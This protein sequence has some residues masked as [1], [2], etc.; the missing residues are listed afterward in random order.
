MPHYGF[1]SAAAATDITVPMTARYAQ[2]TGDL[3]VGSAFDLAPKPLFPRARVPA[4]FPAVRQP[5]DSV[6]PA[7]TTTPV[8]NT[9]DYTK[10]SACATAA[11]GYAVL[12]KA[13]SAGAGVRLLVYS[14]NNVLLASVQYGT[15]STGL[16]NNTDGNY[17]L[18]ELT[19]G[20]FLI[21]MRDGSSTCWLRVVY[22]LGG[23]VDTNQMS[24]NA[25]G[26]SIASASDGGFY[27][28][29]NSANPSL[30]K[31]SAAGTQLW[32]V[33][34]IGSGTELGVGNANNSCVFELANGNVV[35]AWANRYAIYSP[36]GAVVLA[37]AN[38]PGLAGSVSDAVTGVALAGGGFVL[39]SLLPNNGNSKWHTLLSD[40]G[41][42]VRQ[43]SVNIAPGWLR[44]HPAGGYLSESGQTGQYHGYDNTGRPSAAAPGSGL[45]LPL[46]DGRIASIRLVAGSNQIITEIFAGSGF[47]YG[48]ASDTA[49]AGA[50]ATVQVS[51]K[52]TLRADWTPGAF[53]HASRLPGGNRGFIVARTLM[54][55]G[56]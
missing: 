49:A 40:A 32:Q 31:Y 50:A 16:S 55:E 51:G 48:V 22:P 2:Q 38:V 36:A 44:A 23:G 41:A 13:G 47:V 18:A 46:A 7:L 11:G 26:V 20:G 53:D 42:L 45:P 30:T 9:V 4:S 15:G 52:A 14:A 25:Y 17:A 37:P 33:A 54:L 34:G 56:I 27:V 35:A 29:Q 43:Y 8:A 21:S 5:D 3:L 12:L 10:V 39:S 6:C 19:G 28:Q 24:I 1:G